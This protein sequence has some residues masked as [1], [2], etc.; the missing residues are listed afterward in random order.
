MSETAQS[1]LTKEQQ[2]FLAAKAAQKQAP[3]ATGT[4]F[5]LRSSVIVNGKEVLQPYFI[6]QIKGIQYFERPPGSGNLFDIHG[7]EV[8]VLEKEE[9]SSILA[10]N[11]EKKHKK[12]VAQKDQLEELNFQNDLLKK[13]L[14]AAL[15]EA[16][17]IKAEKEQAA[18]KDKKA[19]QAPAAAK[20]TK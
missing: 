10:V 17:S 3:Q 4:G 16:A 8:G 12:I 15:K 13:Q 1:T 14:E 20:E 5:D 19:Q 2:D 6:H 18:E 7:E 11:G 9:G